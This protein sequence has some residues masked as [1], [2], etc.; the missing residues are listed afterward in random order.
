MNFEKKIWNDDQYIGS[1]WSAQF[2][3]AKMSQL[4]KLGRDSIEQLEKMNLSQMKN[5]RFWRK[6]DRYFLNISYPS[7]QAMDYISQNS[8]LDVIEA[9]GERPIA[10]YVHVPFCKA[11]CYYCHYYKKFNKSE[12]EVDSYIDTLLLELQNISNITGGKLRCKSIYFGGGTP[13]YMSAKQI[14]R[15]IRGIHR[16]C[17]LEPK[18]EFS[19]EMHPE[20]SDLDR[21]KAIIEGGVNRIS[22]GVES[23]EDKVLKSE[24]RRHSSADVKKA[25]ERVHKVGVNTIN[26]DF[27]YGLMN[28]T[29]EGWENTLKSA[30]S[31]HPDSVTSYRLRLKKGSSEFKKWKL[32][33]TL[34]PTEDEILLMHAMSMVFWEDYNGYRQSPI[35]WFIKDQ[36]SFHFYQDHNWRKTEETPLLGIGPS[37]YSCIDNMQFYNINDTSMW[38]EKIHSG[39]LGSWKGYEINQD[40]AMRRSIMLGIKFGV[41]IKWFSKTFNRLPTDIFKKE[42]KELESLG[43]ISFKD[44]IIS[45]TRKGTLF[46]DEIGQFFYGEKVAKQMQQIPVEMISSTFPQFN[47]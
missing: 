21:I 13:S 10:L 25:V 46:A 2:N 31:L 23:L 20:S 40:D 12:N 39:N 28:Q 41:D 44:N 5:S 27:I 14:D 42:L 18:A 9:I 19:F 33:K 30:L 11:A 3:T 15:I 8:I 1:N 36:K 38:A 34:F 24:N 4:S 37:A 32:D 7:L 22:I 29:L 17:D 47:K 26:L 6:S 45:L 43:L 16:Y 35:D